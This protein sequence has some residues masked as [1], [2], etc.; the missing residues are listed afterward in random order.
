MNEPP[1]P[2][3]MQRLKAAFEREMDGHVEVEEVDPDRFRFAVT[4]KRFGGVGHLQRQDLLWDIV[5]RELPPERT[6]AIS[7][8]LA[9]DPIELQTA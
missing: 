4:S 9:Y 6:L 2:D 1:L 3:D 8:I 7:L 5:D